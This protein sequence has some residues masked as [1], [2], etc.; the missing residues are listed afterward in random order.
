MQGL[1]GRAKF[2]PFIETGYGLLSAGRLFLIRPPGF[3][4]E[5]L[6][7]VPAG[8]H[9]FTITLPGTSVP[10]SCY[11]VPSG[12]WFGVSPLQFGIEQMV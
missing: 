11:A 8:L 6:Y 7:A 9:V 4:P 3:H 1:D 2:G 12:D 5:G 10:G